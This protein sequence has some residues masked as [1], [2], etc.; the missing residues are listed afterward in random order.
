MK[1]STGAIKVESWELLDAS[2]L[3]S[4]P[5][6]LSVYQEKVQ[7]PSGRVLD[8]FYR[9]VLP[10]FAMVVA[11]TAEKQLVMVRGY[12]H[13]PKR[14]CLSAPGGLVESGESP[15]VAAQRELL[16]ETGY[17]ASAWECMGR[18]VT[19]GNRQCGTAHLFIA[20]D[21]VQVASGNQGDDNE[22]VQVALMHPRQFLQA[23]RQ[24]D[25]VLMA[26]VSAVALAMVAGLDAEGDSLR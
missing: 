18:F 5:P 19:D 9:V 26:T 4:K 7:L 8:D 6:W 24:N 2:L 12:K 11:L 14:T 10:D 13:G 1:Y 3:I 16:E 17:T 21:A 22:Q 15:L 20:R 25:I 23:I